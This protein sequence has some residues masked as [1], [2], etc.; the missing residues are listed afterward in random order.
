MIYHFDFH[1]VS[2]Y[3]RELAAGCAMTI[4]IAAIATFAG[5]VV[6][7]AIA[8]ARTSRFRTLQ[9]LTV[10]YIEIIRNT[11][12]LVQLFFVFF[13]LPAL[14]L[15]LSPLAAASIALTLNCAAYSAEI[16]RAGIGAIPRG[17]YEAGAALG[18]RPVQVLARVALKPALRIIYPPLC[19]QFI[20]TFLA[21][22][23]I[24]SIGI[25]ELTGTAQHIDSIIFRSF[26]IY[27]VITILYLLIA[28]L[29]SYSLR[30]IYAYYLDYP[31]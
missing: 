15:H 2:P 28:A 18:L 6:G 17:Q 14:G 20:L 1:A 22:S 23:I 8:I 21:T 31:V 11:P 10:C 7:L 12:F 29:F 30:R 27:I 26:E 4:G 24:S 16:I 5:F 9:K 3:W 25:E 13:G 19:S